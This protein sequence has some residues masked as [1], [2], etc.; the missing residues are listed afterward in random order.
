MSRIFISHSHQDSLLARAFC[1]WLDTQGWAQDYFV[2]FQGIGAGQAWQ[3]ALKRATG[4]CMAVVLLLSPD[5]CRSDPCR[6][7]MTL[8]RYLGKRIIPVLIRAVPLTV[9]QLK[10]VGDFQIVDLTGTGPQ[11]GF[12]V[13]P[14]PGDPEQPVAFSAD[15]LA[16]LKRGLRDAGVD[17]DYFEW[18]PA[19]PNDSP[20][21]GARALDE[22]EAAL[23]F[24]R[25]EDMQ[26]AID[27]LRLAAQKPGGQALVIQGASGTGKSSFLRAG[28]LPRLQ[29]D[30]WNFAVVVPALRPSNLT[31]RSWQ[32]EVSHLLW[33]ARSANEPQLSRL[34]V[35]RQLGEGDGGLL[36]ALDALESAS[37]PP[38]CG[39]RAVVLAIDQAEELVDP[40][41]SATAS[42]LVQALSALFTQ[43]AQIRPGTSREGATLLLLLSIRTDRLP[44]LM[45]SGVFGPVQPG[46]FLLGPVKPFNLREVVQG[47]LRAATALGQ[48][49]TLQPALIDRLADDAQ[50]DDVLPL[51]ALTLA[52]LYDLGRTGANTVTLDMA[53]YDHM[54][55]MGGVIEATLARA[56]AE[57]SREPAIPAQAQAQTALLRRVF[58]LIASLSADDG[59]APPGRSNGAGPDPAAQWPVDALLARVR[60]TQ[61]PLTAFAS[62]P[63]LAAMVTRLVNHRL[64]SQGSW[65]AGASGQVQIDVVEATHEAVLRQWAGFKSWLV[66]SER[67]LLDAERVRQ[68]A[69][70]WAASAADAGTLL[71]R[72]TRLRA[73][74][75]LRQDPAFGRRFGALEHDYLSACE[76]AAR[77]RHLAGGAA[78]TSALALVSALVLGGMW[79]QQQ[80]V[81]WSAALAWPLWWIGWRTLP[82]TVPVQ[83]P[84]G[85][86]PFVAGCQPE[87]DD[88]DAAKEQAC[89]DEPVATALT[90]T[91]VCEMASHEV[92]YHQYDDFVRSQPASAAPKRRFPSDDGRPRW[93][94]PVVYVNLDDARAYATWLSARTGQT[95]RLPTD[96]EWEFAARDTPVT[97]PFPWG[98]STGPG[99]LHANCLN[100]TATGIDRAVLETEPVDLA[101]RANQRGLFHMA[102]NVAEWVLPDPRRQAELPTGA[103]YAMGGSFK[104][105]LRNLRVYRREVNPPDE[106]R[107]NLGFR[108]CRETTPPRPSAATKS[109]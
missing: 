65:R 71:H 105:N 98:K 46:T 48:Q 16:F 24:G 25:T 89:P 43:L 69:L 70:E 21:P 30:D 86:A 15:G 11:A 74:V 101:G 68:S 45:G 7:E 19:R 55:R 22:R 2:D 81:H 56:L 64:L 96:T 12:M 6:D 20:F 87:R 17:P 108:V 32:D 94:R 78:A 59:A 61:V 97:G 91:Q 54:G 109:P 102:G 60:R 85:G 27:Q 18:R 93:N 103:A 62:D 3:D 100:C 95:W 36:T 92:S 75:A 31:E 5:W 58:A 77:R 51:L 10:G 33:A 44:A 83:L 8:A 38:G 47:P 80:R 88:P 66:E 107:E 106:Q 84:A 26:L 82:Q 42:A 50:G 73:A 99:E 57:P 41:A 14:G 40:G 35:A 4:R 23:F 67:S 52:E 79:T 39:R 13:S 53:G 90:L 34:E 28:L 1:Q 49:V 29:R 72:G 9:L 63:A 104:E 37:R 76:R